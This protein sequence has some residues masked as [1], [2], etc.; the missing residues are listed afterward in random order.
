[1][2]GPS[3]LRRE[4][5]AVLINHEVEPEA[6]LRPRRTPQRRADFED[7]E[8]PHG[9]LEQ[10]LE[11]GLSSEGKAFDA[12]FAAAE[13]HK[14]DF[15][16]DSRFAALLR[17]E[18]AGAVPQGGEDEAEVPNFDVNAVEGEGRDRFLHLKMELLIRSLRSVANSCEI[19][20]LLNA[21]MIY[22]DRVYNFIVK[23][24]KYRLSCFDLHIFT[25]NLINLFLFYLFI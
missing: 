25:L 8:L 1:V 2:D 7:R 3:P 17:D 10:L 22:C 19:E 9:R 21:L 15:A 6:L 5:K 4:L 11:G 16:V 14:V 12:H 24:L 18:V 23:L 20:R 13:R